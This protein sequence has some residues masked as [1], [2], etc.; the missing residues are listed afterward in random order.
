MQ[1]VR[2]NLARAFVELNAARVGKGHHLLLG[3]G[4]AGGPAAGL[5]WEVYNEGGHGA[6]WCAAM[7]GV[8]D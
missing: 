1:L 4:A 5:S 3:I 7:L 8:E 6:L 2:V